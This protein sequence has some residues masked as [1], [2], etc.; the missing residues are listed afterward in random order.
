MEIL[1][2]ALVFIVAWCYAGY[3]LFVGALARLRPRPLR[4]ALSAGAEP[5]VAVIIAARNEQSTIVQRIDNLLAQ[6]YPADRL[7][8]VVVCN[9]T[10]DGTDVLAE[11][12]AVSGAR[13]RVLR[14]PGSEGKSGALNRGIAS[15]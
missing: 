12:F 15:T 14:S 2:W 13:V 10:T 4:Q 3:P 7:E 11:R 9:G 5:T 8:I 1:Y 6:D